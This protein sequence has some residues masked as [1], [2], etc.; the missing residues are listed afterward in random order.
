MGNIFD[1]KDKEFF[2]QL[3]QK[4]YW[5]Y[6]GYVDGSG[7]PTGIIVKYLSYETV[8]KK[9]IYIGEIWEVMC[10]PDNIRNS[11]QSRIEIYS[12]PSNPKYLGAWD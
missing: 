2:T 1:D 5:K 12:D 11:I 9:R 7:E 10:K 6:K 3:K 8:L 4:E